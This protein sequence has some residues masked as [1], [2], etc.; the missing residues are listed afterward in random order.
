MNMYRNFKALLMCGVILLSGSSLLVSCD[1]DKEP[2]AYI[3]ASQ[4]IFNLDAEGLDA[5]GKRP[6]FEL[7]CNRDWSVR[8]CPDWVK[9][10]YTSGCRGR[11]VMH[12]TAEPNTTDQNRRGCIELAAVGGKP[13][14]L[15][16]NQTRLE[17]DVSASVSNFNV[18]MIGN[19]PNGGNP[20]F[21]VTSTYAWSIESSDWISAQPPS[22]QAGTTAVTLHVGIN[23]T[24]ATRS[25]RV[26]VTIGDKRVDI[27]ITQDA[28]GFTVPVD[29]IDID[30]DGTATSA[31]QPLVAPV[32]ALEAWSVTEKPEWL[33]VTPDNG[34]PGTTNITLNVQPNSGDPRGGNIVLTSEHGAIFTLM[35]SQAGNLPFD[36]RQV[37]YSYFWE[38]FDW[39]HDAAEERRKTDPSFAN[40]MD[41]M[42]L[43]NGSGAKN[44]NI[45]DGDGLKYAP[46]F[47]AEQGGK[48]EVVKEYTSDKR[49][50]VFILDGYLRMGASSNTVGLKTGVPLDIENGH[51]ANVELSFKGCKNGTDNIVLVV[52]IEGPGE[53]VGGQTAKLG[54]E[55]KVPNQDKTMK[56]KWENLSLTVNKVTSDTR[57]IIRPTV[58]D[59]KDKNPA[60]KYNR[61]WLI[62]EVS[63]KRVAN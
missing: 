12:L 52:E 11:V 1:D 14:L 19:L 25:G 47:Y 22:G 61:R 60:A 37:G 35:V 15:Y 43:I 6:T 38:P 4:T 49:D 59:D 3:E 2:E 40:N 26:T 20:T 30:I 34:Q 10:N 57:F 36:N 32:T 23:D 55:F 27:T 5:D 7:G 44:L 56:W 51:C 16:V 41:Q 63:I 45:Y 24:R 18:N 28:K 53:I 62:D 31:G 39:C 58:M 29:A 33:T 50:W 42:N 8:I 9:L 13:E 46:Y 48:W 21:N 17:G 54:P